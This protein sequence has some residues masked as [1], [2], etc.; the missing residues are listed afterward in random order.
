MDV[1]AK[2]Q[3]DQPRFHV[4]GTVRWDSLPETLR[5][6]DRTVRDGDTTLETGCGASTVVFLAGGAHHTVISPNKDE[7]DRVRD[8]C[9]KIGLNDSRLTS[10]AGSSDEVLPELCRDRVFDVAFIDGAHSF[11]Y[12]EVDWHYVTRALK[13]GATL[14]IDDVPIPAVIPL[15]KHMSVEPNWRLEAILD[16]RAAAFSL[17]APPA[18]EDWSVQ[19]FNRHYPDCSFAPLPLRARLLGEHWMKLARRQAARSER[20]R[21]A[22]ARLSGATGE[23]R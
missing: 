11:P 8:Y 4:G 5:L 3:A 16:D 10:I 12:P 14:V 22:W 17:L 19:P 18:P 2:L 13:V 15:F 20:L 21:G 23:D 9:R 7:H 1:V 6:I